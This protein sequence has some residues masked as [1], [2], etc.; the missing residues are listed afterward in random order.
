MKA[1]VMMGPIR[2]TILLVT[3]ST[4]IAAFIVWFEGSRDVQIV[5]LRVE[6]MCC[7]VKARCIVRRL[8]SFTGVSDVESLLSRQQIRFNIS[9]ATGPQPAQIW[10]AAEGCAMRPISMMYGSHSMKSRPEAN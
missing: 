9:K 7:D 3:I 1:V 10:D 2:E 5:Q 4:L 6:G 8:S